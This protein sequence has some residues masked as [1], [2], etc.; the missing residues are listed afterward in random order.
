MNVGTDVHFEVY[1]RKGARPFDIDG[2]YD[3]KCHLPIT[4][5]DATY[6]GRETDRNSSRGEYTNEFFDVLSTDH[7]SH[8]LMYRL[9][10]TTYPPCDREYF[11]IL[12]PFTC[13]VP[14][15]AIGRY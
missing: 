7:F 2:T 13:I 3:F 12:H 5:P 8:D 15:A 10:A 9:N 4:D 14:P 6:C 11:R 1:V